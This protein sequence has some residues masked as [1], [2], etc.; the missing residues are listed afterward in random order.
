VPLVTKKGLDGE[1]KYYADNSTELCSNYLSES[2][3]VLMN[4]YY[5]TGVA[6]T[7]KEVIANDKI[8]RTWMN[9]LESQLPYAPN[10]KMYCMHGIGKATER[11][12]LYEEREN[13][14]N[15]DMVLDTEANDPSSGDLHKGVY[16]CE[17]DGTIPLLSLGYMGLKGWR[18]YSHLNPSKLSVVIREYKDDITN[19]RVTD[20]RG[21]PKSGDHVDILGNHALT[22]DLLRIVANFPEPDAP[23]GLVLNDLIVSNL[24]EI[25]QKIDIPYT[26]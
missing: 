6:L 1:A 15:L 4:K 25:C 8:H 10:L 18:Q 3:A 16:R 22:V 26:D 7:K 21:G 17:G 24:E 5:S 20:V 2:L 9:P 13:L 12:Y 11:G 19:L 23:A 14:V